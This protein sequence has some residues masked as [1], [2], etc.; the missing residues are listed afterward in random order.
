M[1]PE[2]ARWRQ[3]LRLVDVERSGSKRAIVEAAQNVGFVLQSATAGIDQDRRAERAVAVK[4]RKEIAVE[5]VPRVRRQRQ[6][7]DQDVGLPQER[8]ELSTALEAG[9]ALDLFW[10]A[11]PAG[12]AKAEPPQYRR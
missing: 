6:Q 10:A 5:D 3:R 8:L 4:P 2:R 1:A 12:H 11:A 9:D 7:A